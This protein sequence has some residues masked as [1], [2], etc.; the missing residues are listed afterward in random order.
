MNLT[1]LLIDSKRYLYPDKFPSDLLF[2]TDQ[3]P[4]H[5]VNIMKRLLPMFTYNKVARLMK[6]PKW[7]I[8]EEKP[9]EKVVEEEIEKIEIESFDSLEVSLSYFRFRLKNKKE[10]KK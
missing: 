9:K 4:I 10:R 6:L 7:Y 1:R 2:S 8:R 3:P 5:S